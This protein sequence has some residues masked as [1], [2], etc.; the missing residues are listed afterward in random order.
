MKK[1][2]MLVLFVSAIVYAS[3][4]AT[5]GRMAVLDMDFRTPAQIMAYQS[6]AALPYVVASTNAPVVPPPVKV[7]AQA[8][9]WANLF[10]WFG[11]LNEMRLRVLPIE[12]S[13]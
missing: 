10:T 1:T 4:C 12:W 11:S 7:E 8:S 13:N 5:R 9:W 2:I 6:E 3:G